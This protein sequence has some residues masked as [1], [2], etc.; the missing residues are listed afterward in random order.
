MFVMRVIQ[1][2]KKT[3]YVWKSKAVHTTYVLGLII[4]EASVVNKRLGI[5]SRLW[6]FLY[7]FIA[8]FTVKAI[9]SFIY[10]IIA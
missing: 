6:F 1:I 3:C 8:I 4:G 9:S 5:I 2:I 10:N 7:N